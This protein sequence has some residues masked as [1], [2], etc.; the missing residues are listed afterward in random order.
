MDDKIY[1]FD[2][3]RLEGGLFRPTGDWQIEGYALFTHWRVGDKE[4]Y[5]NGAIFFSTSVFETGKLNH[6]LLQPIID[7]DKW[8]CKWVKVNNLELRI[9][10]KTE[11]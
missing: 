10:L 6:K 2:E 9:V 7:A 8:D 11:D 1:T 3:A 5:T 4:G